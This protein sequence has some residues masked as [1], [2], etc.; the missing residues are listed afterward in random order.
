MI[1]VLFITETW[2]K[3]HVQCT[4]FGCFQPVAKKNRSNGPRGGV[5][6]LSRVTCRFPDEEIEL[7]DFD[8][9]VVIAL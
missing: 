9:A 6:I 1:D 5:V 7:V 2:W 8:S 4:L 3:D